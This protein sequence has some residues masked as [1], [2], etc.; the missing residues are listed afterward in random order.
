M[1]Q[2]KDLIVSGATRIL[3]KTYSPEFVGKL[4]G[5]ADT[6]TKATGD[7]NGSNIR[8]TYAA[9][10]GFRFLQDGNGV[11]LQAKNGAGQESGNFA[12]PAANATAW[13]VMTK[14]AQVF[15]GEKTFNDIVH[16]KANAYSDT[17]SSGALNLNNSNIYGV[18]SIIMADLADSAAEGIQWYR[19][20]THTDTMWV[21]NG[22][23]YFTPNR[24]YGGTA[25][26]YTI[27]HSNNYTNWTVTKTG[28]GASGT[29]GIN[30][31]GNAGSASKLTSNAGSNVQP[32]YFNNGVPV[33]TSY[34]LNAKVNAGTANRLAYYSTS[35]NLAAIGKI[36][37]WESNNSK[38]AT[39]T[40]L[41]I[42]GPTYGN[43]ASTT[44]SGAAGAL[45]WDDGGPQ[46]RFGTS[47]TTSQDGAL[48]YTDNDSSGAGAS[49]HFVSTEGDVSV[50]SK[51]FVA[52]TS[53]TIGQSLQN[54]SYN[55]YVNG[56]SYLTGRLVATANIYSNRGSTLAASFMWN[57]AG[58]Y[59]G[60]IGYRGVSGENYLGPANADG[61]WADSSGDTWYIRGRLKSEAIGSSDDTYIAF[62][63]GG[64]YK[65]R[66]SVNT[67]YLK[68]TLP[69][70]WT[71]TMLSFRIKI[72]E[73][74]TN[75]SCDYFVSGYNYSDESKWYNVTAYSTGK[76][77]TKTI[78]NL[79]VRFGHD[80]SKCAIYIGESNTSWNY[81]QIRVCDVLT[82]FKNYEYS[83]W[84][85][86]WTVGF[87]TTLGTISQTVTNPN[88]SRVNT[89]YDI[90][91]GGATT[92]AYSKA[93]LNYGDYTWVAVWNGKELRAANKNQFATAGHTH[94]YAGSSSVGGPATSSNAIAIVA[95]NEVRF[96]KP[97]T[98]LG[99]NTL[100]IGYYWA[101]GTKSK[102]INEYKFC[103][104]DGN[105]TQ[106]TA[107]QFNGS[108]NGNASTASS[109]TKL[110]TA[111]TISLTGTVVGSGSF[112]G[113]ANLSISTSVKDVNNSNTVTF[114]Y[115]KAEVG[116]NDI[117]W[118]AAWNGYE[119]RAINKNQF[120]KASTSGAATS[121]DKL[122]T[123]RNI[124]LSGY[125]SGSANFDGSANITIT[126]WGYG[127]VK[128]VTQNATTAPYVRVA[129]AS[130]TGSYYDASMIFSVDS[131]YAGGGY[132]ILKVVMRS[133]DISSAANNSYCEVRWLVRQGFS[134]DQFF[135]KGNAPKGGTHYADLYFKATG[136]YQAINIRV[137]NS[138][139]RGSQSRSWTFDNSAAR[140]NPD[141][142][143]YTYTN[144]GYDSSTVSYSTSSGTA[145][146]ATQ[147]NSKTGS[148]NATE[149]TYVL[150]DGNNYVHLNY[151]ESN[152][153]A[154]ENPTISQ[155]I[156]TNSSDN[157]YRK[158]SLA[159]L[160]SSLGS[161]PASDV[162]AWAKASTKPSYSWSEITSKPTTFTPSSHNHSQIVT[163][164]DKRDDATT[165]NSYSN[166]LIFQGLK[167][168]T[169]IGTPSGDTYSYVIGLR[170]WSNSS[171][172]Y[173]HE[174][175][176]NDSG[177]F[178]RRG[179]TTSWNVGWQRVLLNGSTAT[180][181]GISLD[182]NGAYI[183]GQDNSGNIFF[184]Y[185][186]SS[187]AGYSYTN[188]SYLYN[189]KLGAQSAN[190]YWGMATPSG[191]T[192]D[193]IRTSSAGIIPYQSGGQGSGHCNLGTSS[194][195]FSQIWVDSVRCANFVSSDGWCGN[196]Y[197]S[198]DNWIG[199][200]AT[201]GNTSS[202]RYGYIQTDI[203][204][205][206]SMHF[207]KEQGGNFAFN[208]NIYVSWGDVTLSHA[209]AEQRFRFYHASKNDHTVYLYKGAGGSSGSSTVIG[210][211]DL[212]DGLIWNYNVGKN[213]VF[214][215]TIVLNS[216]NYG[217]TLPSSGVAGQIFFKI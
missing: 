122:T 1:A 48:I 78:S 32:I 156:V 188:V 62:P 124:A 44:M 72:Y 91:D 85:A 192:G 75:T 20:A 49:F 197:F 130:T 138:G 16:L 123:A 11:Y 147:L 193:W 127:Y 8:T 102:M 73:Y 81:T 112:D 151:I 90:N 206:G 170:G 107:T 148:T 105:L 38:G 6:A 128:Y 194:W 87:T 33:A 24:P 3:G 139:S 131:G 14:A 92:F 118:L 164:G 101:D 114:A 168:N 133:N 155:I 134:A 195:Y 21:K 196:K 37:Y 106:I 212:T 115:S 25:T 99:S 140:A 39:R 199:W 143:T 144:N 137:L 191:G 183:Y 67:G 60:G 84:A 95:N 209:T 28:S 217:S 159:H 41:K 50:N 17:L 54:N 104:G 162:Y 200:Y 103:G 59:F 76:N 93:G 216:A 214:G 208:T 187:S 126:D 71:D 26:N 120:A 110:S 45:N 181:P 146:N 205:D 80:G 77:D 125:S 56:T 5:N 119:L 31:T 190:G 185:R 150:R 202:T 22:V 152:T 34:S 111:R 68:I 40:Y 141:I 35:T 47:E 98:A 180:I 167:T 161:M 108:L 157:Y 171:G 184:R 100:Y 153:K 145:T 116:Y 19:D 129:Y 163:V 117:T 88:V 4:T 12:I 113:S 189:N 63:S 149:N 18:N 97:S 89:V 2:L 176:F 55:L 83:K 53:V 136:I 109:A 166:T 27:M 58:T 36:G 213:I 154:S 86:G 29:W 173:S 169:K 198:A 210:I 79:T 69:Q 135:V 64:G 121:A 46:I 74:R 201:K 94:L 42:W 61:S 52:R 211:Y 9:R 132:G 65:T 51:R 182:N 204:T 158:A 66:T 178:A 30:I 172:G 215:K 23:M 165:P 142:R 177:I 174:L 7:S 179:S 96:T 186:T 13:G 43:T 10:D 175:A 15:A 160:K 70:S 82:G 203:S 207:V 57:K